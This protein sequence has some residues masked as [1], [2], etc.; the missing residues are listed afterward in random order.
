MV[1]A[2]LYHLLS[3]YLQGLSDPEEYII[4]KS[5]GAVKSLTELGLL[6]KNML[7]YFIKIV[8]PLLAHPVR[9]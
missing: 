1:L 7:H 8:T 9:S 3:L 6:Q 4:H 5:L 2:T